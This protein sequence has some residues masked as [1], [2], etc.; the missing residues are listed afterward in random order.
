MAG[1]ARKGLINI[2][3]KLLGHLKQNRGQ[4]VLELQVPK[5]STVSEII[6]ILNRSLGSEFE[7]LIMDPSGKLQGGI[8][9]VLNQEHLPARKT[10]FIQLTEDC[11]LI[12][13]PMI[14]GGSTNNFSSD[15]IHLSIL[16]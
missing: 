15:K 9:I 4:S 10:G 16:T 6:D 2:R 14:E 1:E 8:E 12:L 3:V 7:R 13:M 11:E 5:G